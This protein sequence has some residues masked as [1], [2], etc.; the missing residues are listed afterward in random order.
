MKT[1]ALKLLMCVTACVASII[2]VE[3]GCGEEAISKR[4]GNL[5]RC[6]IRIFFWSAGE[7]PFDGVSPQK[8][9][10]TYKKSLEI[11][12]AFPPTNQTRSLAAALSQYIP[13]NHREGGVSW[14]IF[15]DSIEGKPLLRVFLDAW[16]REATLNDKPVVFTEELP[17]WLVRTCSEAFELES[18]LFR[19]PILKT[20]REK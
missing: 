7:K 18:D 12:S 14:A 9:P 3:S 10:T 5:E 11:R 19:E 8:H 2:F 20:V 4:L 16:G 13:S 6:R 17:K 15:I 1:K